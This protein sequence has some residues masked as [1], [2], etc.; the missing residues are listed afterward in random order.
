MKMNR[1][2]VLVGM[3]FAVA[4]TRL[5]PHPANFAPIVAVALF[6][7][8]CFDKKR[9]ALLVTF[10]ALLLSDLL[11]GFYPDLPVVY[12]AYLLVLGLGFR[13]KDQRKWLPVAG[14]TLASSI[15]FFIVTNF[16]VWA[17]QPIYPKTVAGLTACYIAAIPF[18]PNT[19]VGDALY[20]TLLF[21]G[22]AL[23]ERKFNI[24]KEPLSVAS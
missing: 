11:I 18:F 20:V 24:L 1:F 14:S 7:G 16:G 3:V 19:L 10:G 9:T 21:G 13:L 2:L 23:A 17:F 8:A 22:F 6:G 15:L 4:L 12:L 5:I